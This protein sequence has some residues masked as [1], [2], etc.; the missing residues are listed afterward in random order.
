MAWRRRQIAR[1]MSVKLGERLERE[2]AAAEEAAARRADA[3]RWDK[4]RDEFGGDCEAIQATMAW[5]KCLKAR[6]GA[7][8]DIEKA[9]EAYESGEV[10]PGK[11]AAAAASAASADVTAPGA[12]GAEVEALRAKAAQ[13]LGDREALLDNLTAEKGRREE[14]EEKLEGAEESLKE[15]DL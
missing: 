15:K 2:K 11:G 6:L 7:E 5:A 13:L 14:C 12:S 8:G 1:R 10:V 4:V 9:L 3:A